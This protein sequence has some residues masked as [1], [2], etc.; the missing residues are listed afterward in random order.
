MAL[1][2]RPDKVDQIGE[3]MV[4]AFASAGV[5]ARSIVT[6]PCLSGATVKQLVATT[7]E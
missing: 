1:T 3:G 7:C 6:K 4:A 2:L 5:K